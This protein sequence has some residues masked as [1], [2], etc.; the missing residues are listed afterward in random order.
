MQKE[1]MLLVG[2]LL[3][4][5]GCQGMH[6]RLGMLE[7]KKEAGQDGLSTWFKSFVDVVDDEQRS[8]SAIQA[9]LDEGGA[10]YLKQPVELEDDDYT[11]LHYVAEEGDLEVVTELINNREVPVDIQTSKTG[12]T[13][14]HSAASAGKLEVVKLLVEVHGADVNALDQE[15]ASALHYA[16]AGGQEEVSEEIIKFLVK[17]GADLKKLVKNKFSVLDLA[18]NAG[19]IAV[20]RYLVG[21]HPELMPSES[22]GE[23]K[24]LIKLADGLCDDTILKILEEHYQSQN[25]TDNTCKACCNVT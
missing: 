6:Q 3:A 20:V 12:R 5:G 11:P 8:W 15:E 9:V 19:N 23:G 16:A 25:T 13:P 14:L 22:S 17:K 1:L 2:V 4:T 24:R 18:I 7:E 10:N 21:N